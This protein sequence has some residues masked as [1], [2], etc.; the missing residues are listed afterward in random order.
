MRSPRNYQQACFEAIRQ[1]YKDKLKRVIVVLATGLG[2]TVIF[3]LVALM[4]RTKGGRVLVLVN[5]D[6]LADQ[7]AKELSENGMHPSIERGQDKASPMSDLVVGSIQTMCGERLKKWNPDHYRLVICDECH[8]SAS[9]TFKTVLDYFKDAHHIGVTATPNRHDKKGLWSGYEKIVFEMPLKERLEK[10]GT[11]TPGGIEEGW[12]CD[13]VF[14]EIPVPITL[15]D[16]VATCKRLSEDEEAGEYGL[17]PHLRRIFE[18]SS[19]ELPGRKA[20][21]FF[22][23]CE[24]SYE[25]SKAYQRYGL[26][27]RHIEGVSGGSDTRPAMSKSNIKELLEWFAKE[28]DAVLCNAELLAVGYNQ[29]DINM[30]GLIRL[31]KSET[32]YLQKLGRGTRTIANVDGMPDKQSRLDAIQSSYKPFCTVLDL[33]IQNQ[34]HNLCNP[35]VLVTADADEQSFLR[36]KRKSGKVV[37]FMEMEDLLRAKRTT[38]RDDMLAKMSE[39]IANAAAKKK[40]GKEPYY[41]HILKRMNPKHKGASDNAITYLSRLGYTGPK[42]ITAQACYRI[43]ECFKAHQEKLSLSHS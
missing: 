33:C 40:S 29:P 12:L 13:L 5:R 28:K 17:E 34:D 21:M 6:V 4:V 10:D 32:S 8:G 3:V 43:T 18:A 14:R 31:I 36:E 42:G 24:S 30:I 20:L 41:G 19:S 23:N 11:I 7:A 25:A 37:D 2:K 39:Q 1:A 16:K 27:A 26:N 35:A 38:D 15:T 22:P 9:G